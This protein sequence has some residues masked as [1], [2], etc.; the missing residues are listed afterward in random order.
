MH[1]P[2][3]TPAE[4]RDRWLANAEMTRAEWDAER[5]RVLTDDPDCDAYICHGYIVADERD[6]ARLASMGYSDV[7]PPGAPAADGK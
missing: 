5:L 6:A 7:T 4:F 3:V 2:M 1:A